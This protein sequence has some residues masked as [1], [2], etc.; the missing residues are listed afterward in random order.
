MGFRA[1]LGFRVVVSLVS[2]RADCF[3]KQ[4]KLSGGREQDSGFRVYAKRLPKVMGGVSVMGILT[5]N[6]PQQRGVLHPSFLGMAP[7]KNDR[8]TNTELLIFSV[9]L[10]TGSC[11]HAGL[12]ELCIKGLG[13]RGSRVVTEVSIS[14]PVTSLY[15]LTTFTSA[16]R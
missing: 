10:T 1:Y 5:Y 8:L 15:C 9:V 6:R 7:Y 14:M 12:S 2:K 3:T 4:A 16:A 11:F 13:F